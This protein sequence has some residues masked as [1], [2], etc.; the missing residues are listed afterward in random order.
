[1]TTIT[2]HLYLVVLDDVLLD[3][4]VS[5]LVTLALLQSSGVQ[6]SLWN[7]PIVSRNVVGD[8]GSSHGE[9]LNLVLHL[10]GLFVKFL[11]GVLSISSEINR[12]LSYKVRPL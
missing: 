3:D 6:V 12:V 5:G 2:G 7:K 1:V 4:G 8:L 11:S 9:F 10:L